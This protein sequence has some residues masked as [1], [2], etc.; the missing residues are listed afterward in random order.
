MFVDAYDSRGAICLF[1]RARKVAR[2]CDMLTTNHIGVNYHSVGFC[3]E[4]MRD[5][6][7]LVS[8]KISVLPTLTTN[9]FYIISFKSI[10][11]TSSNDLHNF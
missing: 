7:I 2:I 10:P 9:F 1:T 8:I 6:I 11:E 4:S 3:F 5:I